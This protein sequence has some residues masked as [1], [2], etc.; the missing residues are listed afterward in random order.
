MNIEFCIFYHI[1]VIPL[2]C[3]LMVFYCENSCLIAVS[4]ICLLFQAAGL[5][6]SVV[7]FYLN[8]NLL[9]CLNLF[10]LVFHHYLKH[11]IYHFYS[12]WL[13]P[14]EKLSLLLET[15]RHVLE[16]LTLFSVLLQYFLSFYFSLLHLG[17]FVVVLL[18]L[19]GVSLFQFMEFTLIF[20][21]MHPPAHTLLL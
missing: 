13:C 20:S 7:H 17:H 12:Y 3:D 21:Y 1:A 6:F 10:I 14:F 16:L 11:I 9:T 5:L 15:F 4:L 18:F 2:Y 19:V 8:G